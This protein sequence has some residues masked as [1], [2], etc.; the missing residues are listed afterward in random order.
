MSHSH[1]VIRVPISCGAKISKQSSWIL[2]FVNINVCW[3]L[4]VPKQQ[5]LLP[6]EHA[7]LQAAGVPVATHNAKYD[8][9]AK[10][11]AAVLLLG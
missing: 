1:V 8:K 9:H 2:V 11:I 10:A 6:A 5:L 3:C 4:S 7:T